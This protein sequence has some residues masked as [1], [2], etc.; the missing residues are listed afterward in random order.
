MKQ[1]AANAYYTIS[2]DEIK[3]RVFLS[4]SGIW[5]KEAQVPNWLTDIQTVID[6]AG[7][8]F[9]LVN[10]LTNMGPTMIPKLLVAAQEIIM[11][12]GVRKAC[13][14]HRSETLAKM[15]VKRVAD[16]SGIAKREFD[17]MEEAEAWMDEP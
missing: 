3:N 14:I 1:V 2:Y 6:M 16:N 7:P 12:G 5:S 15:A 9:T 11:G 10:D 8:R 13:E 4:I 17:N